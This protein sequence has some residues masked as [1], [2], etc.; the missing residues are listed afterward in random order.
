MEKRKRRI[1]FK[2]RKVPMRSKIMITKN[3]YE[4]LWTANMSKM[5]ELKARYID[6]EI[7]NFDNIT[8]QRIELKLNE[9]RVRLDKI[10]EKLSIDKD[11]QFPDKVVL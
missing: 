8:I 6:T 5:N 2:Y 10:E 11:N 9:I 4:E 1:T 3:F 7:S